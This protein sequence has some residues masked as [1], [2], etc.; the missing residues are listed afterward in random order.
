MKQKTRN[1][2]VVVFILVFP[3]AVW[4]AFFIYDWTSPSPAA[5]SNPNGT[6]GS[7]Q[8]AE[9]ATNAGH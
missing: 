2:I 4:T 3:A 5:V 8:A 9:R 1:W 6:H 7:T